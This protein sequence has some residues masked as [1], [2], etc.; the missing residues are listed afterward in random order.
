MKEQRR[1]CFLLCL[2]LRFPE[3]HDPAS[4]GN[5]FAQLSFSNVLTWATASRIC[6]INDSRWSRMS[7][8]CVLHKDFLS[9]KPTT[10]EAK[11]SVLL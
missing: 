3:A 2:D 5:Q 1:N 10:P 11:V 7:T 4:F 6:C 9:N 8:T